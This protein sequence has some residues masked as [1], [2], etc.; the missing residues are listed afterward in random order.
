MSDKKQLDLQKGYKRV[1]VNIREDLFKKVKIQS[2]HEDL[3]IGQML[4]KLIEREFNNSK[5]KVKK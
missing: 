3:R 5:Y 4:E 1:N 2:V